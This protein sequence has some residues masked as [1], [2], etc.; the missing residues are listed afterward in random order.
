VCRVVEN[1]SEEWSC[2][3]YGKPLANQS[4]QVLDSQLNHCPIWVA[5]EIYIGGTGLALGYLR[6]I[7]LTRRAFITHPVTGE[8]LYKTG[9]RGRYLPDGDIE[10]LGRLDHQVKV[11]GFRIEVGEVEAALLKQHGVSEA[12]VVPFEEDSDRRLAAFVAVKSNFLVEPAVLRQRLKTLLPWYMVPALVVV[13]EE[14]P[15]NRNGKIDRAALQSMGLQGGVSDRYVAPATP[16]ERHLSR[17]FEEILG[18]Q[19][20][21][22][23]D[24]FFDLGGDS[25]LATK[26]VQRIREQLSVE[27]P[28]Q[29]IFEYPT[30]SAIADEVIR[31]RADQTRN[32][33]LESQ[34]VVD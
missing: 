17:V 5:G 25:I 13:L 24:S 30:V 31:R 20:V 18:V 23:T 34:S 11:H 10:F 1:A 7:E 22:S 27:M 2:V 32:D 28:T 21:G 16:M 3:P 4:V 9:D 26:L 33:V 19:Q 12:A 8:R 29:E 14:L 6:E 15:K